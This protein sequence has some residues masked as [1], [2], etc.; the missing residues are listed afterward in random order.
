ML[1][2][3]WDHEKAA[4]VKQCLSKKTKKKQLLMKKLNLMDDSI[5][6]GI[7]K[8]YVFRCKLKYQVSFAEWRNAQNVESNQKEVSLV[9]P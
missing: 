1:G 9:Q 5:K 7:I 3:V 6:I 2:E 4:L 8:A